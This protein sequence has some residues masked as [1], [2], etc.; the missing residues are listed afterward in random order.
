VPPPTPI[1]SLQFLTPVLATHPKKGGRGGILST[2]HARS[3]SILSDHR[4]S[5]DLPC[6]PMRINCREEPRD[7][8]SPFNL[9]MQ[10]KSESLIAVSYAGSAPPTVVFG[11][12]GGAYGPDGMFGVI[13]GCKRW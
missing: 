10:I 2:K 4:E 8:R 12:I 6:N 7:K 9:I 1:S 3:M 13:T 11:G 5:R